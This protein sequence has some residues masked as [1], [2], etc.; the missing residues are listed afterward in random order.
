MVNVPICEWDIS[1]G[2]T[3]F[4]Y[5]MKSVSPKIEEAMFIPALGT[6]HESSNTRHFSMQIPTLD[7]Y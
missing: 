2:D 4:Q 1:E 5:A 7:T 6:I 3:K